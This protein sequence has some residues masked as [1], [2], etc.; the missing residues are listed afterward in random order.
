MHLVNSE[1]AGVCPRATL[2][3]RQL[4]DPPYLTPLLPVTPSAT[5]RAPHPCPGEHPDEAPGVD[6]VEDPQET[7]EGEE[8]QEP[9]VPQT[10]E[11]HVSEPL[12]ES[13]SVC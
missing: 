4:P 10:A 13:D 9:G 3:L 5:W 12:W 8:G 6:E 7:Q 11:D 2:W 1:Y